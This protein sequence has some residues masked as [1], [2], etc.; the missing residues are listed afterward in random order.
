MHPGFRME[1]TM[2]LG[3]PPVFRLWNML[4]SRISLKA[5]ISQ[6]VGRE[7][8]RWHLF[9]KFRKGRHDDHRS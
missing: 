9:P 8:V 7:T 3:R 2:N 5:L 4:A 1:V 6:Q